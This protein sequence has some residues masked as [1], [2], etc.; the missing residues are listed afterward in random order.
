VLSLEGEAENFRV[1]AEQ[2]LILKDND[3]IIK[4]VLNNL[5]LGEEGGVEFG[6]ALSLDSGI[7]DNE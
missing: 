6:I 4:P 3:S 7:F 2:M 1:L 5:S